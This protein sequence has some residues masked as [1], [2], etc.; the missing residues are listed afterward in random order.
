M[1]PAIAVG[2]AAGWI[3]GKMRAK[4]R[5]TKWSHVSEQRFRRVVEGTGT[6]IAVASPDDRFLEA[7]PAFCEMVG[8][9]EKEL[10]KLTGEPVWVRLRVAVVRDGE[11]RPLHYVGTV[12]NVAK[13]REEEQ[14]R[15]LRT[16]GLAESNALLDV[17]FNKAPIGIGVWDRELRYVRVNPAMA[18]MNGL[19]MEAHKGKTLLELLP[20]VDP[21]VMNALQRVLETGEPILDQEAAGETPASPGKLRHWR[22]NYFPIHQA[23]QVTGVGVVCNEI[24]EKRLSAERLRQTAKLESLGVLAGGIA[25]DFNNL[26]TGILGNASLLAADLPADSPAQEMIKGVSNA[27]E[28]AADLTR[29]LLAYAGKGRFVVQPLDLTPMVKEITQL[30]DV[31][32][33][34]GIN[35]NYDLRPD[36][37]QVEADRG[38]MQQVI[39]NLVINAAEAVGEGQKGTV[40]VATGVCDLD[41]GSSVESGIGEVPAGRYVLLEVSDTGCGMDEDTKARIFDPFFTTKFMGRGLG[42]SAVLG[43]VRG[44]KGVLRVTSS[45]GQGCT[46]QMLLP[47]LAGAAEAREPVKEIPKLMAHGTVLVVD[48]EAIVRQLGTAVLK[49]FGYEVLLAEN[50]LEAVHVFQSDPDRIDVVL[51]DMTMPKMSGEETLREILKLKPKARVIL[52]SG[53]NEVEANRRFA[54]LTF[55]GFIQKPY[56]AA[57]LGEKIKSVLPVSG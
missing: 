13:A 50:G 49:H 51:L 7:N 29:Q 53:Y 25:H 19:A 8:Y 34:G 15:N 18:E 36:L 28:R 55:A 16:Q 40:T 2:V 57:Q 23:G 6:G 11:R 45:P 39:M 56:T 30:L 54:G 43:I 47:A 33:L 42:L 1:V 20:K 38:Q 21:A 31:S 32:I 44:H 4:A 14:Q 27:G 46:F 10:S 5:Y 26:L 22:V 12:E 48:D 37:P 9:P 3:L 17:L 41:G 52:S 24:T 35:L